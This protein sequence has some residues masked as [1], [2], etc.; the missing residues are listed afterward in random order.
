[1]EDLEPKLEEAKKPK[2]MIRICAHCK[3]TAEGDKWV[4]ITAETLAQLEGEG[5]KITH[6]ICPDCL[7]KEMEKIDKEFPEKNKNT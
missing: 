5:R 6:G 3:K 1:M 2:E 7:K 4:E